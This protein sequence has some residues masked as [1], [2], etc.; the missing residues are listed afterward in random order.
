MVK[1]ILDDDEAQAL[2]ALLIEKT[3]L[4]TK[5][6]HARRRERIALYWRSSE[7][8]NEGKGK[9]TIAWVAASHQVASSSPPP[10]TP[11]S[12]GCGGT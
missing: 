5:F 2:R 4:P 3:N 11:T 12:L 10:S 6:R 7:A 1:L 9:L 8:D